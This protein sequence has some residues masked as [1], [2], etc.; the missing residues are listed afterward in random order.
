MPYAEVWKDGVKIAVIDAGGGV[1]AI[2]GLVASVGSSGSQDGPLVAARRA[3]QIAASTGGQVWV[4]GQPMDRETLG[5]RAK[6]QV[7]YGRMQ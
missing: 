6:L 2:S 3:A 7:A 4:A 5:V 1:T